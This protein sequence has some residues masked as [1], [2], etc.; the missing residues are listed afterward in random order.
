MGKVDAGPI[1]AGSAPDPR[2]YGGDTIVVDDSF[3]RSAGK[4]ALQLLGGAAMLR[5]FVP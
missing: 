2:I 4:D 1:L 3:V 5:M